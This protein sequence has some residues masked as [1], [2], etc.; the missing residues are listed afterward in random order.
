[1]AKRAADKSKAAIEVNKA[2]AK[3]QAL[4]GTFWYTVSVEHPSLDKSGI[5]VTKGFRVVHDKE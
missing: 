2:T 3:E 5:S 1:M 4:E